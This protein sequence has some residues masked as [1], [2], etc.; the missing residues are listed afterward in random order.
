MAV[1]QNKTP[2]V[3]THWRKNSKGY[4]MAY[5]KGERI[6]AHRLAWRE[7]HGDIPKGMLVRHLCHNPSC[8][9]IDHLALGTHKDN[10]QDDKDA[11]RSWA[12]KGEDSVTGK[13]TE[14]EVKE[15]RSLKLS[16]KAPRGYISN[17]CKKYNIHRMTVYDIWNRKTWQHLP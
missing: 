9:N 6:E 4:G 17:I 7:H 3:E 12:L 10:R 5:V 1:L 15:I 2:C 16:H 8:V 11:G 14:V 13:L